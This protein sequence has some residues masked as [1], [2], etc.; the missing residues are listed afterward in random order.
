LRSSDAVVPGTLV[1]SSARRRVALW[2]VAFAL[3]IAALVANHSH[4]RHLQPVAHFPWLNVLAVVVLALAALS[5]GWMALRATR[6]G[7]PGRVRAALSGL[8]LAAICSAALWVAWF[9]VSADVDPGNVARVHF[10]PHAQ[11]IVLSGRILPRTVHDLRRELEMHPQA[12][13]VVVTST[14]GSIGAAWEAAT[15]LQQAGIPVRIRSWCAS[16]C[17]DLWALVTEREIEDAALIGLHRS[18]AG[19]FTEGGRIVA[20]SLGRQRTRSVAALATAGFPQQ[21][22]EKVLAEPPSSVFWVHAH[23]A[24]DAGVHARLISAHAP[25]RGDRGMSTR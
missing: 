19:D 8:L 4:V 10:E 16:A 22:V 5:A 6:R 15:L 21:L 1:Q 18:H 20:W 2:S 14:G 17:V 9:N 7:G 13:R 25:D 24:I 11:E 3:A 23:E 12:R